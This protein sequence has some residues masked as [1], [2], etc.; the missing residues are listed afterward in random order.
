MSLDINYWHGK[1]VDRT[2][3]NSVATFVL[4]HKKSHAMNVIGAPE[5]RTAASSSPRNRSKY[6]RR[7]PHVGVRSG[8]E[9]SGCQAVFR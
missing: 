8:Y 9:T 5:I 1:Y 4:S 6:T 7:L 2:Y 3:N